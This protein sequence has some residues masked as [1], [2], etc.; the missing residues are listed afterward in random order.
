[1]TEFGNG[2]GVIG[3]ANAASTPIMNP[4][5][6]GLLYVE[7]GALKYRGPSGTVTTL[8]GP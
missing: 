3:M 6:G 4:I 1:M 2:A 5:D 8:P 7:G